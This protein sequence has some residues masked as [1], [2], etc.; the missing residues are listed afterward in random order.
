MAN[1]SITPCSG[2]PAVVADFNAFTP[3][4]GKVYYLTFSFGITDGCYTI[5]SLTVSAF[6]GAVTSMSSQY[7]NCGECETVPTPTPTPTPTVTSTPTLT[8][9]LTPR[10]IPIPIPTPTPTYN[11]YL[12]SNNKANL[13]ITKQASLISDLQSLITEAQ[14]SLTIEEFTNMSSIILNPQNFSEINKYS[15][16]YNKNVALLDDPNNMTASAF[17]TY[18]YL[19]NK[20]INNLRDELNTLQNYMQKNKSKKTDIKAFKS[21]NNSQM[22]NVELYKESNV[23]G[24]KDYVNQQNNSSIY[25]N[26]LIYGNNGCLQYEPPTINSK[27]VNV[28]ASWSFKSCNSNEPKQQFI[29]NKINNLETYNSYIT[30]PLNESSRLTD[31][32]NILLGFNVV[33]PILAQDQCLQLNNDGLSVMPCNIDFSQRFKPSYTE[34]LP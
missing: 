15:K 8:P 31:S 1:Y 4:T 6:I 14:K 20:K 11:P 17:N 3:T 10:P 23:D 34:V 7:D 9:T 16:T 28:P 24:N 29:S 18:I 5:V 12:L 26:Y 33:N 32:S 27:N 25:P 21:M 22:L 13:I 19:Q 2:G 30:D